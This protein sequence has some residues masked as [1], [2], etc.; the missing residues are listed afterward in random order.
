MFFE[1]LVKKTTVNKTFD[2]FT[3]DTIVNSISEFISD[4]DEGIT[5]ES[6]YRSYKGI[7]KKDCSHWKDEKKVRLLSRKLF[8]TEH[9][10]YINFIKTTGRNKFCRN[11]WNA[12]KTFH[13]TLIFNAR[14]NY[15]NL[16]NCVVDDDDDDFVT[17]S[18]V[19]NQECEK[20]ELNELISDSFKC[21]IFVQGLIPKGMQK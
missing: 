17:Y 14:Q 11:Y 10:K 21:L 6:Y 3:P 1:L 16:V 2:S 19:V 7:F 12:N 18:R 4:P 9:E 8:P 13:R 15:L 5:S 20:F